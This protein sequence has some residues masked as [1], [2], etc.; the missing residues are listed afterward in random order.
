MKIEKSIF[1]W[2][3]NKILKHKVANLNNKLNHYLNNNVNK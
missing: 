3:T 1:N 2:N